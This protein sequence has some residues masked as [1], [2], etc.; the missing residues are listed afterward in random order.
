LRGDFPDSP[1]GFCALRRSIAGAI[2]VFLEASAV[3]QVRFRETDLP[4]L[5]GLG[6]LFVPW[7]VFMALP[8]GGTAFVY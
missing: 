2:D 3:R 4:K 1:L 8:S 7:R 6:S 5:C